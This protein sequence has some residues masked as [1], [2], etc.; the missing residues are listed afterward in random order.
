MVSYCKVI[1]FEP[2]S[3]AGT[4]FVTKLALGSRGWNASRASG[5][6]LDR[7]SLNARF[8]AS[9]AAVNGVRVNGLV[10]CV[11]NHAKIALR[12]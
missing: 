3:A 9:W 10:C 6:R 4:G 7:S 1:I 12:S 11:S 8:G 2:S 5:V